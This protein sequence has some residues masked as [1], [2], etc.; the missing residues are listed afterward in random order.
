MKSIFYA[1]LFSVIVTQSV[2]AH[3][4]GHGHVSEGGKFGGIMAPIIDKKDESRGDQA[5]KLFKAELVRT[6]SGKLSLY[7]FDEK[8]NLV[9]LKSF[10]N[11][12]IG[13]LEV[14]K[15]G[16]FTYFGEVKFKKNGNHFVAQLPQIEYRP[17]NLD[18]Y[19]VNSKHSLFSGFSN[20]D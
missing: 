9:D 3:E 2:F 15:K 10:N 17:F 11:E 14:K 16:K 20:L 4:G 6:D 8:M 7:V 18:V 5:K 13:K 19:L 12:G 1:M